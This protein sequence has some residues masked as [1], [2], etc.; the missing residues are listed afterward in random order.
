MIKHLRYLLFVT[1]LLSA[2]STTKYLADGQK[3][4]SGTEIIVKDSSIKKSDA[5]NIKAE[6][7]ALVRPKPNSSLLGLRVKLWL[8]FKTK[9]RKGFIQK[10]FS[11]YGEPPVLISQVDLAK[12]STIMQN[13]LQ[14][15]S[16]F[17]A[18]VSGDTVGKAKTAKAV[19]TA[20]PGPPYIIR[21]VTFPIATDNSLDT[22]VRGTMKETLL[23]KGDKYNLDVIKSE[24]LRI[25]ARLKEKGF[26]YFAPEQLIVQYDST[27]INH[28]VDLNVK[29]K[30]A[31]PERARE[32]YSIRN[33]YVYPNYSLRD[34]SLKLDSANAYR[35][36]NIVDPRN[37]ARPYLFANTVLLHPN[38]T[39]SR[40]THNNSL[41][42]FIN[43]GPYRYVKNRF[44]DV[45]PDSPKLDVYYFLTPYKRKSLQLE[46]LGRTTSANYTGSQIN[47]S[48]KNRNAFKGGELLTFTLFASTD[49]QA[50]GQ[51]GGFNVFQYGAQ[52]SLSWPRIIAPFNVKS[53]N[54]Y[55][56]RTVL[57]VG[58]TATDRQKLYA[59]NTFSGSFGYQFKTDI[60]KL[61]ELNLLEISSTKLRNVQQL[62]LDSIAKT[63]NPA[64]KHVIDPQFTWGPSYAYSYDNTT[65][66]YRTNSIYYRGKV[67]LSNN[68]YGII[69]GA[70][71]LAGKDKK[72]LGSTFN[73]YVKAEGEFRFFH[74]INAGNKIA[75]RV[76]AGVGLPYGNSTILPYSQQFFIGGPNSLRGFRAR[77]I[78]PGSVDATALNNGFIADQSGDIKLEANLEYRAKLFS[79][80]YGALFADAGN[81]WNAKPH[82]AGGTFGPNFYKQL[83]VDAGFGLRFDA[84]VLVLRT[85]L[86]FP[87]ITPYIN[88]SGSRSVTP[89]FKNAIFNLAIGYPF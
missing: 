17:Q 19:F 37:T 39:Y 54:A 4:Y 77:S 53:S 26:F 76:L 89:S 15:E 58:Y 8:Y 74:K 27:I 10:F 60:H 46:L 71:T 42:R 22:A 32:I 81:V 59:L 68:L 48:W 34:T 7:K 2:C 62:Y 57:S 1:V 6:M 66:D 20:L 84:T 64:L 25:D 63:S 73:Q 41:N 82:Q 52:T 86:G 9:A 38:D 67:S 13:R 45:T 28:Q 21:N 85:D 55:I 35:W 40:T 16:Y 24:R 70:D 56:P 80:V 49:V 69:T 33:I 30:P 5:N 87:L 79:I 23:K 78:G 18:T 11:K 3:L 14:N 88:G 83:G 43:L 51:N 44:E 61:H 75:A 12:N 65:E 72:F 36:Y 50:G 29:I 31:T 47:L